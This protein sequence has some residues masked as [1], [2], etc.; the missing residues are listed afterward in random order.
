M[1]LIFSP[2]LV[3]SSPTAYDRT[4]PVIGWQ[5]QVVVTGVEADFEEDN[6]PA[7]NLANPATNLLWRSTSTATQYVTFDLNEEEPVDYI[8]IARHNLGSTGVVIS[9][10]IQTYDSTDWVELIE[11]FVVADDAPILIRFLENIAGAMRLKLVPLATAP[12]MGVVYIGQMLV[13]P[14]GIP[15]GHTPLIDGRITRTVDGNS[16]AGDYLGSIILSQKLASSV[17]FQHLDAAWY[18]RNMRPLVK[19]GRGTPFFWSGFPDSHPREAGYAW[20]TNDPRP[21]FIAGFDDDEV[22]ITL[23]MGG[24]IA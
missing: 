16:E 13:M 14:I 19:A 5:S 4:A 20:L 22:S 2:S 7:T 9:V 3:L 12:E 18:R 15:Q 6:F 24:I 23:Q 21:D 10:E 11:G 8:G 17:S 1:P